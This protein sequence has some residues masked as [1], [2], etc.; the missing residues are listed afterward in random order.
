MEGGG[1]P[2]ATLP[3][4]A[5]G[6]ALEG[7]GDP[8]ATLPTEAR[9]DA[10]EGGGDPTATLPLS[11]LSG[12]VQTGG[13]VPVSTLPADRAEETGQEEEFQDPLM[14]AITEGDIMAELEAIEQEE[15]ELW[16]DI[17]RSQAAN[18]ATAEAEP[19]IE[20]E[21]E[22]LPFK[23]YVTRYGSVYHA[24]RE[25]N[26]LRAPRT[27]PAFEMEW[28][29]TCRSV[30]MRT[31]GRPPPGVTLWSKKGSRLIHTDRRCPRASESRELTFCTFC[32]GLI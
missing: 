24:T 9:G 17:N 16:R 28:C 19:A 11:A 13:G 29:H 15:R 4:D 26:Y 21:E 12:E 30:A 2:T 25:C 23:V 6:D 7:G 31:R 10:L 3:T 5:R 18:S 27:G 22:G 1:D 14:R 32:Q 20:V 8:T